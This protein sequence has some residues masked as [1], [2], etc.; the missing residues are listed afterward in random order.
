VILKVVDVDKDGFVSLMDGSGECR[1]DLRFESQDLQ[2]QAE[3]IL[4]DD[5]QNCMVSNKQVLRQNILIV[6]GLRVITTCRV[7]GVRNLHRLYAIKKLSL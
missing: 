7:L 4:K 1:D 3:K 2:K 6:F 5:D